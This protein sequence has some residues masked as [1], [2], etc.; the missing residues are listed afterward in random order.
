MAH[1]D[2][3]WATKNLDADQDAVKMTML[4]ELAQLTKLDLTAADYVALHRWRYANV[5]TSAPSDYLLDER[6]Q[7]AACGDWCRQGR[8]EAAWLSAD[9]LAD[10]LLS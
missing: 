8:I 2:N 3:V 5:V 1:A 10:K 4:G 7:L 6:Q 9:A